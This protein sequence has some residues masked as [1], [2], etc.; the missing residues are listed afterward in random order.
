M[1]PL[2]SSSQSVQSLPMP[3]EGSGPAK[4][5]SP[6]NSSTNVGYT[7]QTSVSINRSNAGSPGL[8]V[9]GGSVQ[10]EGWLLKWTNY[11]LGHQERY[12]VLRG[13]VLSYY[14]CVL[15]LIEREAFGLH[16]VLENI[17]MD[18]SR[19]GFV[20]Q[21]RGFAEPPLGCQYLLRCCA[22]SLSRFL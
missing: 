1:L 20:F 4:R 14:R 19:D 10:M 2:R 21:G 17:S 12:F 18:L 3:G 13:N 7:S 8:V 5:P 15:A 11:V 22:F 9:G 16:W 6:R